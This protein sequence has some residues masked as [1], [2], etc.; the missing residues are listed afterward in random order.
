MTIKTIP[1]EQQYLAHRVYPH[2]Y[3]AGNAN[4]ATAARLVAKGLL[5]RVKDETRP[6]VVHT[7]LTQAGLDLVGD[8]YPQEAVQAR[9]EALG[10]EGKAK[11]EE[12]DRRRNNLRGQ[13]ATRNAAAAELQRLVPADVLPYG[14][15]T[16][17]KVHA[18]YSG[19]H[20]GS[21]LLSSAQV[22]AIVKAALDGERRVQ[23]DAAPMCQTC[24][25]RHGS[26][27][28]HAEL[29]P[30]HLSRVTPD[31]QPP[32]PRGAGAAVRLGPE[33]S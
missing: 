11:A 33:T 10:A 17:A 25:N 30:V 2:L 14:I 31:Q 9:R 3:D 7:N 27:V 19:I 28:R 16:E 21:A 12:R 1:T 18:D 32:H 5:E 24:G 15:V 22:L 6:W 20:G 4:R 13:A 23:A 26:E 29:R 8:L